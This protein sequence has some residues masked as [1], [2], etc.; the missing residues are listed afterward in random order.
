M[1]IEKKIRT[2]SLFTGAGGLDIGF[3]QAGFEIV[4]CLE[5]DKPSCETLIM[6]VGKYLS[7]ST[8]IF[9]NDITTTKP[10]S[11]EL[12]DIDFII[13]GPPCQSF[14]AAGRRA[15]GV[16]GI[17]DTRGSLFWYYC[18]YL[19]YFQPTGFL[20]E[21]VKGIIQANN[22]ADW[23]LIVQSFESV[24]YNITFK[25]LDAADFGTPQ[26]RERLIMVGIRKDKNICFKFPKATHGPTGYIT[27]KYVTPQEALWDLQNE[28]EIVEP[29][30]GK[31]GHLLNDI[32]PGQNYLFYTEKMGHPR[33]QF[34]WRS[35][36]SGF[37][38]KLPKD[39][40]SKTIVAHQGR[41]DGPFH[42]NNRKLNEAELKRIQG[43]PDDYNFVSSK[44]ESTR[45]I[46]NSVA[47]KMA[48]LLAHAIKIQFFG[49]P[50]N[51]IELLDDDVESHSQSHHSAR[52]TR[53][54]AKTKSKTRGSQSIDFD[55]YDFFENNKSYSLK[56][57]NR[58]SLEI[59]SQSYVLN[60]TL[61]SGIWT[62]DLKSNS[63]EAKSKI[64]IKLQFTKLAGCEFKEINAT[65][66][67][68][69]I[70]EMNILW[71]TIHQSIAISSSYENLLPLYGHF[72]EPYP[73]FK[74]ILVL[75]NINVLDRT[76][77]KCAEIIQRMAEYSFLES[78]HSFDQFFSSAREANY[79]IQ[80]LR[81]KGFDIRTFETNRAIKEGYFKPCYPFALPSKTKSYIVWKEKGLHDTGDVTVNLKNGS[82][83][84]NSSKIAKNGST[85]FG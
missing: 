16:H 69:S 40:P 68:T 70:L 10:D 58:E 52:K 19:K 27:K 60:R 43:F 11:L 65:G 9:N 57:H 4:G 37:L 56:F 72:T 64:E 23:N 62:I 67:L 30:G 21:N 53:K 20:F 54:A 2:L 17:N 45:Q 33:P 42:W 61:K 31:Y 13:G 59:G 50:N 48:N 46:G 74:L 83:V 85:K 22:S 41:Y 26:H 82:V 84:I 77:I 73:K 28:N 55:Q 66:T 47:P 49:V 7:P 1:K 81:S 18:E 36:F 51:E 71:D 12:R 80:M 39:E 25:I 15:G 29:Y 75:N 35:K 5:V 34:A 44:V 76:E 8:K 24:G 6:N 79:I 63:L 14:S 3:H 32:P 38:Y 78:T